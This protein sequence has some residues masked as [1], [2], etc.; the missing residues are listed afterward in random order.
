MSSSP[1]KKQTTKIKA[2]GLRNLVGQN[3]ES[4][5]QAAGGSVF[6]GSGEPLGVVADLSLERVDVGNDLFGSDYVLGYVDDG[7]GTGEGA[8]A[9][10]SGGIRAGLPSGPHL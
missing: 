8:A 5:L 7:L 2:N 9:G 4:P 6:G 10:R 1:Q 3:G